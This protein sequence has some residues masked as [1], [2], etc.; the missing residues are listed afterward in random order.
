VLAP[1]WLSTFFLAAVGMWVVWRRGGWKR[2]K[3]A[4]SLYLIHLFVFQVRERRHDCCDW[5]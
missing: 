3:L 5:R 2:N 4:T 1:V